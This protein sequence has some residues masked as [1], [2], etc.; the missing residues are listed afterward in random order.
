MIKGYNGENRQFNLEN[1]TLQISADA[2]RHIK[3]NHPQDLDLLNN[4][5]DIY[6]NFDYARWNYGKDEKGKP[7]VAISFY[8]RYKDG[9]VRA[10]EIDFAG[11]KTLNLKTMYRVDEK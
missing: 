1:F 10:V 6:H 4:L 5:F 9:L 3:N 7:L 11:L 2:I 8:K